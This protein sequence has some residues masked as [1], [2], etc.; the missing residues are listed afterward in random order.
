MLYLISEGNEKALEIMLEKYKKLILS[1]I[2][3]F[4]IR[5]NQKEDYFQEGCSILLEAIKVFNPKF[6]KTFTRFFELLLVRRFM[7]LLKKESKTL[8]SI[9]DE[10]LSKFI[11]KEEEVI[12]IQDNHLDLAKETLSEVEYL[13]FYEL[14]YLENGIRETSM[15]L[16]Y[17][18]K[19]IYN[20]IY[21]IKNK[22][23]TLVVVS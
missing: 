8:Y 19:R 16:G 9:S 15:K 3:R 20:A 2:Y 11:V 6:N 12:M 4:N 23:K 21:R 10:D 7:S 18:E 1:K 14:Y 22:M 5:Q 17:S 13:I